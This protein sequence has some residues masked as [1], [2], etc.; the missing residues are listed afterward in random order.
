VSVWEKFAKEDRHENLEGVWPTRYR[1]L[2]ACAGTVQ[3]E[4]ISGPIPTTVTIYE[5][6]RLVGDVTVS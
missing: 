5:N 1:S 2:M 4:D 6:S 3:A